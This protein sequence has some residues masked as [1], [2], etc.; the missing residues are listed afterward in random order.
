VARGRAILAG[1][2]GWAILVFTTQHL[3]AQSA[4]DDNGYQGPIRSGYNA[5]VG[6]I[7][8]PTG[9]DQIRDYPHPGP[10]WAATHG[11]PNYDLPS[12]HFD[13]WFRSQA[14]GLTKRERCAIPDPWRPRGF[15]NLFA[16]PST[17]HRMDYHRYV[18]ADP[19]SGYGPSYYQR[20]P[21]QRCCVRDCEGHVI[22]KQSRQAMWAMEEPCCEK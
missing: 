15:G 11:Y 7:T 14:W 20:L 22:Y 4:D 9:M 18:L 19:L 21:D 6:P 12:R 3:A 2:G 1:I 13:I 10:E 17:S 5:P 8:Q 16:R